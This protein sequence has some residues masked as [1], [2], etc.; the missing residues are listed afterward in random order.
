MNKLRNSIIKTT[1]LAVF[2]VC[3]AAFLLRYPECVALGIRKGL[4]V[5]G[6]VIIPTL[7]PFMVLAVFISRSDL[8]MFFANALS[9]FTRYVFRLPKEASA[10]IFMSFIGG[11]PVGAKM[12]SE[13]VKS[14]KIS[15]SDAARMNLF[16][17]NAGPAFIISTVGA[18]ML[19]SKKAGIILFM[20]LTLSSLLIG[21]FS[22]LLFAGKKIPAETSEEETEKIPTT[23]AFVSSAREASVSILSICSWVILFSGIGEAIDFLSLGANSSF[24]LKSSLEVTGGCL[25]AAGRYPLPAVAAVIGFSGFC[26]HFQIFPF[27]KDS[28]I[29]ISHF[30]TGRLI[31]GALAAGICR[32]LLIFFP[33]DTA[34]SLA[35]SGFSPIP[36]RVSL[37]ACIAFLIMSV[38]LIFDIAPKKKVC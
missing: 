9:A 22:G 13:L 32:I 15:K 21:F 1:P 2:A 18:N 27:L 8:C 26:V 35:Q 17:I 38:L 6:S 7:F 19:G 29:K 36:Y 30:Y 16:C 28:G 20:S 5:C 4:S 23:Y 11:F 14:G 24:F 12:G 31:S 25:A 10:A 33:C 37:P 3:A 34:V